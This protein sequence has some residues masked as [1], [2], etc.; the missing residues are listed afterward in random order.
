MTLFIIGNGFDLNEGL[1][2]KYS[3]FR[4]YLENHNS[5]LLDDLMF[6]YKNIFNLDVDE[7]SVMNFDKSILISSKGKSFIPNDLN[8]WSSFEKN[9]ANIFF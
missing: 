3:D 5:K 7:D 1:N 4:K 9:I 8:L 2:T 6:F